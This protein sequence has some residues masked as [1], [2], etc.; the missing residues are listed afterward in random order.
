VP[1]SLTVESVE[2]LLSG[3][4]GRPY[5]HAADCSSPPPLD[6]SLPEG[7]VAVC[8]EQPDGR[9]RLGRFNPLPPGTGVLCS[10]LLR[11]RATAI[12]VELPLVGA[13]AAADAVEEALE[14]AAQIKWPGD[15]M[16]NRSRVAAVLAGRCDGAVVLEVAINVNQSREQLRGGAPSPAGSLFTVDGIRRERARILVALLGRLEVHYGRWQAGGIDAVYDFLGARDFLRGRKVAVDG[17]SG[18][19][20]GIDRRG[21]LEIDTGGDRR[22]V[23]SGDVTYER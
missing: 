22:L 2:P 11:P 21:R 3:S 8:D 9:G 18:Y 13:M 14:L 23:E 15:V 6:P 7:A 4:F 17:T 12:P 5:V 16:V 20:V 19:A 10:I 1:D